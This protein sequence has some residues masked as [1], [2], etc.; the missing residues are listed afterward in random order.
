MSTHVFQRLRRVSQLGLTEYVFPSAGYSRFAHS[1]GVC[2]MTGR[3][4][5]AVADAGEPVSDDDRL[6]LRLAGLL[7]DVGHYPY[8]HATEHSVKEYFTKREYLV[9]TPAPR[10]V[11]ESDRITPT[12]L[13]AAAESVTVH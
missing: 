5:D 8:S 13:K 11:D 1:L 7:H 6:Y 2:H 3:V 10:D 4:L 12:E 9:E